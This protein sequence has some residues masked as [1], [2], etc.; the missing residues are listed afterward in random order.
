FDEINEVIYSLNIEGENL[1][2]IDKNTFNQTVYK[3][4]SRNIEVRLFSLK[5]QLIKAESRIETIKLARDG[6]ESE[7]NK[8]NGGVLSYL[9][10]KSKIV[11]LDEQ[12][13]ELNK[14]IKWFEEQE[15]INSESSVIEENLK[16]QQNRLERALDIEKQFETF[17]NIQKEIDRLQKDITECK[18]SLLSIERETL[19]AEKEKNDSIVKLNELKNSL[20]DNR[21][22]LNNIPTQQ[23]QYELTSQAI[24]ELQKVIVDLSKSIT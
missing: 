12:I 16:I 4:L 18:D 21:S 2:L 8:L 20:E 17:L 1:G 22:K 10:N 7:D 9:N 11:K 19:D 3:N 14:I 6:E 5:E 13:L 24:V 23:D 15:K